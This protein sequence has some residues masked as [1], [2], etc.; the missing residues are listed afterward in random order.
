M[1]CPKHQAQERE[2]Q[3]A[4]GPD[5]PPPGSTFASKSQTMSARDSELR[6]RSAS[7][8]KAAGREF[9]P[10]HAVYPEE[11]GSANELEEAVI[12]PGSTCVA[13]H[14]PEV[15]C[16]GCAPLTFPKDE[17]GTFDIGGVHR[18]V[19]TDTLADP[20][21]KGL[22]F[23]AR[24]KNM[25]G[26]APMSLLSPIFIEGICA[27]LDYGSKKY[28]PNMW[29]DDPMT[30]TTELDSIFRHLFAFLRCED[31][32]AA[33]PSGSGLLHLFNA[34]CRLMFLTERYFTHPEL[35]DRYPAPGLDDEMFQQEM[36]EGAEAQ[37]EE[38]LDNYSRSELYDIIHNL[39]HTEEEN[40]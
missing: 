18:V 16:S 36:H 7:E 5:N 35:D 39:S 4:Y 13:D 27:V 31:Y 12:D 24:L 19:L 8:N 14:D 29:R 40:V 2:R 25:E 23:E 38:H 11:V 28:T 21:E 1:S 6:Y 34:G 9:A 3:E 20:E 22:G 33:P 32:D 30:F 10:S 26:K 17:V 15:Y 37:Y